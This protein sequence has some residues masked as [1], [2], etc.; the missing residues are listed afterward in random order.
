ME[1]GQRKRKQM[2]AA[3][4]FFLIVGGLGFLIYRGVRS[5]S[6]TPTPNPTINLAPIQVVDHWLSNV[7]SNDY[8]FLAKITNS[9]TD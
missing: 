6:P 8:D 9:N 5:P 1:E 3:V 2:L 7:E 4:I